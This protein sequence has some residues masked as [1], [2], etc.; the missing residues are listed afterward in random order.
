MNIRSAIHDYLNTLYKDVMKR[1]Y[2]MAKTLFLEDF[3]PDTLYLDCGASRGSQFQ[4]L[5]SAFDQLSP[6]KYFG[7]E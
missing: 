4:L 6:S 3:T 2:Q 1:A 5:A 7:I